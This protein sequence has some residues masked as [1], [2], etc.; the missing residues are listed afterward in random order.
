[1]TGSGTSGDPYIISDVD[2]LQAIEDDLTAYYELSGDIDAS[3]T[4]GW[5]S[6]EGFVPI[7]SFEGRLDGKGYTI[8]GLFINK[9]TKD[10][11]LFDEI[12]GT[13]TDVS[14]RNL[15][16]ADVDITGKDVAALCDN[17]YGGVNGN[18][19]NIVNVHSS[20]SITGTGSYGAAGLV[21]DNQSYA[22]DPD[23]GGYIHQCSSSCTVSS[24]GSY[25]GG[26]VA[27]QGCFMTQSW[28]TGN[29]TGG[30]DTFDRAGGC[31]GSQVSVSVTTITR[32]C[33]ARGNVAAYWVG[34][35]AE[36]NDG[37]MDNC[38]STGTVTASGSSPPNEGGFLRSNTGNVT[39]CFWDTESSSEANSPGGG[40]GK[41]TA[42]MK[43]RATFADAGWDI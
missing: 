9:S 41:T 26:L 35:F 12:S 11:G 7:S 5:N 16:L 20:G 37:T 38:Y 40:T 8:T 2:D 31:I 29:V 23:L 17:N 27:V 28:A 42:Q 36:S 30:T 15:T 33:Y 25:A 6:G 24:T 14:V 18:V 43:T 13:V 3:A 22:S 34:G 39:D 21:V 4:S 19:P 10:G 1:M 32:D